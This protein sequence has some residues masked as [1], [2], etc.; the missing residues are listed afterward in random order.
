MGVVG[1]S[2]FYDPKLETISPQLAYLRRRPADGGAFF[3]R[4]HTS[5]FDIKNATAKS[6]TRRRLYEAGQYT[7]VGYK[8]V[9]LRRDILSWA[10]RTHRAGYPLSM[11]SG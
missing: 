5:E 2:W 11:Q 6:Q 7:P 8:M 10:D 3:L 4:G 9:W 1:Y